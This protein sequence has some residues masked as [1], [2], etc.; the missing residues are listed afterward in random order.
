MYLFK[1]FFLLFSQFWISSYHYVA[2]KVTE[3]THAVTGDSH[4]DVVKD[5]SQSV[6]TNENA[7]SDS[8][9]KINE[10]ANEVSTNTEK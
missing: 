8:T 3:A 2:E 6:G 1:I 9:E 10:Q 7:A 4:K 5:S